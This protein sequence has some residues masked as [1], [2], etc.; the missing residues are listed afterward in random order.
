MKPYHLPL[1]PRA[2]LDLLVYSE[3]AEIGRGEAE[4]FA[5]QFRE[6]WALIFASDR[7]A[8]LRYWRKHRVEAQRHLPSALIPHCR[9]PLISLC[10]REWPRGRR[11]VKGNAGHDGTVLTFEASRFP[12]RDAGAR[13]IIAHE[14]AHVRTFAAAG[15]HPWEWPTIRRRC[16]WIASPFEAVADALAMAWGFRRADDSLDRYVIRT[17]IKRN[18]RHPVVVWLRRWRRQHRGGTAR[19]S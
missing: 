10:R 17:V 1:A 18:S 2:G 14:L 12:K 5:R 13:A 15:A 6:A 9:V 8:I 11:S 16:D 4:R 3:N 19:S 7:R